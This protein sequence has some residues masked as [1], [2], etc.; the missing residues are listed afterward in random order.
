MLGVWSKWVSFR[1]ICRLSSHQKSL[2]TWK[3]LPP[4]GRTMVDPCRLPALAGAL[5]EG[6]PLHHGGD[7]HRLRQREA[8]TM[9][10]IGEAPPPSSRT[11]VGPCRLLALA[12]VWSFPW[13]RLCP[14]PSPGLLAVRIAAS[15]SREPGQWSG[16][17]E[18]GAA[19][20]TEAPAP[21]RAPGLLSVPDSGTLLY[22][23]GLAAASRFFISSAASW[24][25]GN[26]LSISASTSPRMMVK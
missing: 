23:L 12:G 26:F 7:R 5:G 13:L 1:T 8:R 2:E 20:L 22:F 15:G 19:A 17:P 21:S 10:R 25:F 9:E 24:L 16:T 4:S 3:Q 18:W 14:G 11:T 6:V